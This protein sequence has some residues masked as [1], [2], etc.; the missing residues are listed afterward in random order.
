MRLFDLYRYR[1]LDPATTLTVAGAYALFVPVQEMVARSGI[2][3]SLM[4]F[5]RSRRK[6][7]LS[8][9]MSTLLFSSTHLHTGYAFAL[10]SFPVGLFW[11][12]LYARR[13]TLIGVIFSHLL[14]GIW[15]VFV[16]SFPIF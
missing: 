15:A 1:G 8:I 3:S 2:Q 12:W 13:P 7:A 4:M 11:G 9:F 10:S 16:V 6:V 14:I 5:L